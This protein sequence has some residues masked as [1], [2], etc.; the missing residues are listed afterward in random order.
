[1]A[2]LWSTTSRN[3]TVVGI[4]WTCM[5]RKWTIHRSYKSVD[6]AR[7][8]LSRDGSMRVSSRRQTYKL[9]QSQNTPNERISWPSRRSFSL[10]EQAGHFSDFRAADGAA[11]DAAIAV[12]GVSKRGGL[13]GGQALRADAHMTTRH[14][15]TVPR[16]VHA[17]HTAAALGHLFLHPLLVRNRPPLPLSWSVYLRRSSSLTRVQPPLRF[18]GSGRAS[19]DAPAVVARSRRAWRPSWRS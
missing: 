5:R 8:P 14:H 2:A 4:A 19:G 3:A 18:A 11:P 9:T 1:M 17:H 7:W 10:E 15:G 13:E 6:V 12:V 16:G